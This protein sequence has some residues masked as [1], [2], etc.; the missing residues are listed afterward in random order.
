MSLVELY[1]VNGNS[2]FYTRAHDL[3]LHLSLY[4][5]ILTFCFRECFNLSIPLY[6]RVIHFKY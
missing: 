3:H 5:M 2:Y 6:L 4:N 1:F